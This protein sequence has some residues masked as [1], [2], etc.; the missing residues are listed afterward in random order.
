MAEE[1]KPMELSDD[2]LENV[3]GG[4]AYTVK[5]GDTLWSLAQKYH[6]TVEDIAKKNPKLIKDVNHIEVG[7]KIEI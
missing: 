1:S 7:W 6:T 4:F 2:E 5:T 3:T